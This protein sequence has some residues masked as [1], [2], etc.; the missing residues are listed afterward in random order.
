MKYNRYAGMLPSSPRNPDNYEYFPFVRQAPNAL[1]KLN[2]TFH[3]LED[4]VLLI[5][6]MPLLGINSLCYIRIT[7]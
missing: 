5:I 2:N 6:F 7:E 3:T 1:K 4:T